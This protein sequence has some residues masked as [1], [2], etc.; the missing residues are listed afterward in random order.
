M[1]T[2]IV[3]ATAVARLIFL[4]AILIMPWDSKAGTPVFV[5][6]ISYDRTAD[7]IQI[8]GYIPQPASTAL[9]NLSLG[10]SSGLTNAQPASTALTNLSLGTASGL[11]NA[12]P[13]STALTNLSNPAGPILTGIVTFGGTNPG[14]NWG[15]NIICTNVVGWLQITNN[16]TAF[17][18]PLY[19]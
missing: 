5:S 9:T 8:L 19:R 3:I 11:T 12:Q 14:I 15:T 2:K 4:A 17:V 7:L 6:G 16:N 1:K 13:A 18:I 10:T